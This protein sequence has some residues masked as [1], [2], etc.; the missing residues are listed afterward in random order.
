MVKGICFLKSL[1]DANP[2]KSSTD[3]NPAKLI[4][5]LMSS[6]SFHM[7]IFNKQLVTFLFVNQPCLHQVCLFMLPT[8]ALFWNILNG[9][10]QVLDKCF[11]DAFQNY[12]ENSIYHCLTFYHIYSYIHYPCIRSK[13]KLILTAANVF[14]TV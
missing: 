11:L 9:F 6:F 13:Y 12:W 8:K 14:L 4:G 3:A 1:T 7:T 10:Y 2:A 5:S